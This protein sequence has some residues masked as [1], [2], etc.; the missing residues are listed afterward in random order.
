MRGKF[1]LFSVQVE[2]TEKQGKV[3]GLWLLTKEGKDR[4][5][6]LLRQNTG[7]CAVYIDHTKWWRPCSTGYAGM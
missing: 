2:K 5:Y 3:M 6:L 1:T 4:V 7:Q